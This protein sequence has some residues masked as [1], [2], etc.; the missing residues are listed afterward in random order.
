[1]NFIQ[2]AG[3]YKLFF[4]TFFLLTLII[5]PK[6]SKDCGVN[7]D[8]KVHTMHGHMLLDYWEGKNDL[9]L[10]S[11][12]TEEGK[13][14]NIPP[15]DRPDYTDLNFFGGTFDFICAYT[16]K[17]F[18]LGKEVE[19]RHII[20]SLFGILGMLFTGLLAMYI[21]GWRA[22]LLALIFI[23]LS[24]RFIGH[25]MTNPKDAPLA[26]MFIVSIFFIIKFVKELPN[27]K[28][29]TLIFL[30][31]AIAIAISIRVAAILLIPYLLL[32]T[33]CKEISSIFTKILGREDW[34]KIFRSVSL[35]LII[36]FSGYILTSLFWPYDRTSPLIV[37]IHVL[38][39]VS[40]LDIFNSYDLFEGKWWNRDEIPWYYVPKWTIIIT[41][42]YI[43]FGLLLTP[44][45]FF[46]NL[47]VN[48][49]I[50]QK[51]IM[52][53]L[54]CAIF[55]ILLVIIRK[56][57][58]FHD[59]RHLLFAYPPLVVVC[60]LAW[61][62]LFRMQLH[63]H[64]K[65]AGIFAIFIFA[66]QPLIW[67][68]KNH[69]NENTYFSPIVGGIDGAFRKYETDYYGTS[70]R[71]GIDWI[72]K[73]VPATKVNPVKITTYYGS[74]SCAT[75]F[76]DTS[77]GYVYIYAPKNSSEWDYSVLM[78][79]AAKLDSS[80]LYNWPPLGTVHEIKV[81]NT[82]ICA[83]IKN[84]IT[85]PD[86]YFIAGIQFYNEGKYNESI[87]EYKKSIAINQ[88]NV[89]C[90]NNIGV[91]YGAMGKY[92]EQ[93][94][95]CQKALS[96]NPNYTLAKNNLLDAEAKQKTQSTKKND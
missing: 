79:A 9:A 52:A 92:E 30:V 65:I 6:N 40:H 23:E 4:F 90:W 25:S 3:A 67:M 61:E 47:S 75:T 10:K 8:E 27:P 78:A 80:I 64:I 18:P 35:A 69:P 33:F 86:E 21:G 94:K 87:K 85:K 77:K 63:Q 83:V 34:G 84:P 55:P 88:N 22:G 76:I 82:P 44:F 66:S 93:I 28:K 38:K 62:N 16:Y 1:M 32:F 68:I 59:G 19:H 11:P 13:L 36:G 51:Q 54:F 26:T 37:P 5:I 71:Q 48:E 49:K 81:D 50:N 31:F 20:N 72:Q 73:N 29:S 39:E 41:P 74:V 96:I 53:I 95:A 17:H 60:A 42:L 43:L 91:A 58:V 12:F 45:V 57:Y 70:I 7:F 24:P 14:K 15:E 2:K 56:S 46:N 89:D